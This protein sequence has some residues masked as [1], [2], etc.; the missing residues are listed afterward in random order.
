[1]KTMF[2]AAA[3]TGA[4]ALLVFAGSAQAQTQAPQGFSLG[5]NVA[6]VCVLNGPQLVATSSVGRAVEARLKQLQQAVTA[7]LTPEKTAI[8]NEGKSIAAAA[9]AATTAAQQQP[10]QA[11]AQTLDNRA[12]AY[13][14]KAQLRS[15]ELQATS[16]KA[17]QR[18]N[19]E[20]VPVVRQVAAQKSCGVV[21]D[22]S[23]VIEANPA[24]DITPAVIAGLNAKIQTV[25][26]ERENL[27][28]QAARPQQ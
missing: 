17:L 5:G 27:A 25:A 1:M 15:A 22:S 19:A 10:L 2:N 16:Q 8:E 23:A 11:R 13:Q 26:F 3:A 4:A 20:A 21:L 6:G 14:Q 12:N 28:A 7:E 18:I 9:K 24:M